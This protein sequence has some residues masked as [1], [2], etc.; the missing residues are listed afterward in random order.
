MVI[1]LDFQ[2]FFPSIGWSKVRRLFMT[3]GYPEDVANNLASLTTHHIAA[4]DLAPAPLD[5]SSRKRLQHPHLPQGAPTSPALANLVAY[6]FDCR[7]AGLAKALGANYTRYAD[8]ILF[9]GGDHI[10]RR[11]RQLSIRIMGIALEEGFRI[12]PHKTRLM[13]RS[14]RQRAAG[15]ILNEKPNISRRDFDLLKAILYNC[16]KHGWQSQNY[17]NNP[18]FQAHLD[19]RIQWIEQANAKRGEKLRAMYEGIDFR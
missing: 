16:Q 10:R 5:Y 8:D 2:D 12:N 13:Y 1:K 3:A 15:L 17:A 11:A 9:S 6:R 7:V 19:G 18:E 4:E 14:Q